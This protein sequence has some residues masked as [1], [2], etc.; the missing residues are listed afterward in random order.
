[1]ALPRIFTV[2]RSMATKVSW[3]CFPTPPTLCAAAA[4]FPNKAPVP[5]WRPPFP[6][7]RDCWL[8][9]SLP[10]TFAAS[11]TFLSWLRCMAVTFELPVALLL[12]VKARIISV[13]ALVNKRRY[14]IV[15]V[16]VIAAFLT[17]PDP[18]SQILL[19]IPMLLMYELSIFLGRRIEKRRDQEEAMDGDGQEEDSPP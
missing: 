2:W 9:P 5:L 18:I 10:P 15:L 16:F 8:S 17:P 13:A 6:R 1:M 3:P 7:P 14:N 4:P 12:L 19:A 11:R